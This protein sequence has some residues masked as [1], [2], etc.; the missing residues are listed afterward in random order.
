MRDANQCF[1]RQIAKVQRLMSGAGGIW[2]G[3]V[4]IAG[5]WSLA[6]GVPFW[7][8][9]VVFACAVLPPLAGAFM[10]GSTSEAQAVEV[11][12]A[13]WIAL[14]TAGAAKLHTA[15]NTNARGSVAG[16]KL[17]SDADP[18]AHVR[19]GTLRRG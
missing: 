10:R 6:L 11:E 4:T 17:S 14:A 8:S 13:L 7:L 2:L 18:P 9:A 5:V 12:S 19:R 15:V 16:R 1:K 3:L